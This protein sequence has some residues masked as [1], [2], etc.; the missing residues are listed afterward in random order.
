[1]QKSQEAKSSTLISLGLLLGEDPEH[2]SQHRRATSLQDREPLGSPGLSKVGS[3]YLPFCTYEQPL[4][5]VGPGQEAGWSS[6]G[7]LF[8][9]DSA[10]PS[11]F[12]PYYRSQEEHLASAAATPQGCSCCLGSRDPFPGS[13]TQ[14]GCHK[15]TAR[16]ECLSPLAGPDLISGFPPSPACC[17]CLRGLVCD[18][19]QVAPLAR[20]H[21]LGASGFVPYYRSPEERLCASPVLSS[22]VLGSS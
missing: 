2:L 16:E 6:R 17:C 4:A 14:A 7:S 21:V 22:S 11:G 18:D 3:E 15:V 12:F 8:L 10:P 5:E 1:M 13:E 9:E 19:D 20:R